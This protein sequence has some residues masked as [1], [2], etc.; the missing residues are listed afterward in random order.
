[1]DDIRFWMGL[2]F[3]AIP[4]KLAGE[5]P[6]IDAAEWL[7]AYSPEAAEDHFS[8]NKLQRHGIIVPDGVV[9]F[10]AVGAEHQDAL[11]TFL[12]A[13]DAMPVLWP[14]NGPSFY[15]CRSG[16]AWGAAVPD[17][18][19]AV[20]AGDI[21]LAPAVEPDRVQA[22]SIDDLDLLVLPTPAAEPQP[23]EGME[24]VKTPLAGM[25]VRGKAALF[26]ERAIN[27]RPLLGNVAMM[28]QGT[29]WYAP[30]NS[31][32]TLVMLAL[33]IQAIEGGL[34]L[35]D[36]CYFI[37]ADD[38]EAGIAQ[39]L[40]LLDDVGAH[41]LVPGE[42]GF[43]PSDFTDQLDVMAE[44]DSCRGVVVM[45]DTIK[46]CADLMDKKETSRFAS[47]VRRFTQKGGTFIGLAHTRK[48]P[49][50][51]GK[52]VYGGTTDLTEDC[53]AVFMLN[54]PYDF[55]STG[56]KIVKFESLKK[57]GGGVEEAYAF[58]ADAECYDELLISV[59]L[60][61]PADLEGLGVRAEHVNDQSIFDA[62]IACL[63]DGPQMKM[64]LVSAVAARA[65][66]SK[67]AALRIIE[68]F[69]DDGEGQ[70]YWSYTV[71]ARGAKVYSLTPGD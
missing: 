29:V 58:A 51:T 38:N 52:L 54:S 45:L 26:E 23:L 71:Q 39:K 32:K 7:A 30:P 56:E 69:G 66:V 41:T 48:N 28:G 10:R 36:N 4:L 33:L 31:G 22:R 44:S 68:Q 16:D 35:P 18:V 64:P 24:L 46:K 11:E 19:E 2:G 65:N 57:R 49:S 62:V 37:N 34:V 3:T 1:M 42:G 5:A 6:A 55:A 21:I 43:E 15:R 70:G 13:L 40:R 8:R 50:A 20:M 27:I 12:K 63:Q 14:D 59:R 25:S 60:V 9:G 67:R 61:D 17:G 47:S 53:D